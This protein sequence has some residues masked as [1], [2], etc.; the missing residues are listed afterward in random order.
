MLGRKVSHEEQF[1][2]SGEIHRR[3]VPLVQ[4][5]APEAAKDMRRHFKL[6]G[7]AGTPAEY[8]IQVNAPIRIR[9]SPAFTK[10]GILVRTAHLAYVGLNRDADS[11]N[12]DD[13]HPGFGLRED[14][15]E[16]TETITIVFPVVP[17]DPVEVFLYAGEPARPL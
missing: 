1:D 16:P 9:V 12:Y 15:C 17:P 13:L 5:A 14:R 11:G 10:Y 3:V 6:S 2:R 8:L 4:S 7:A